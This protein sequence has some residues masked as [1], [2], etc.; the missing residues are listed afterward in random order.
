MNK[1]YMTRASN[2]GPGAHGTSFDVALVKWND[3]NDNFE[4]ALLVPSVLLINSQRDPKRD[5]VA[6]QQRDRHSGSQLAAWHL[7]QMGCARPA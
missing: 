4:R 5:C 2:H 1:A 7:L 3:C 6:L